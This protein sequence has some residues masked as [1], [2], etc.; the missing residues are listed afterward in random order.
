MFGLGNAGT[1]LVTKINESKNFNEWEKSILIQ[2][3]K[4]TEESTDIVVLTLRKQVCDNCSNN[5][6]NGGSGVC[7][8]TLG[9]PVIN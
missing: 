5:P 3:L 7:H 8:C 6:K 2:G 9:S 1:N 4:H